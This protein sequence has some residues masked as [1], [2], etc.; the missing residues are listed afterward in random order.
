[1]KTINQTSN[2]MITMLQKHNRE[3]QITCKRQAEM[4]DEQQRQI[5]M[6]ILLLKDRLADIRKVVD[7]AILSGDN[8]HLAHQKMKHWIISHSNIAY[9]R[10]AR[11][12]IQQLADICC[13]G[14]ISK[15]RETYPPLRNDELT[16]CAYIC[17]DF[18]S[19]QICYLG[20]YKN[21]NS[22]YNI[23]HRIKCKLGKHSSWELDVILKEMISN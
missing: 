9:N 21:I 17:L 15:L 11:N 20:K 5:E 19:D 22:L 8:P 4:L 7:I 6:Y 18:S 2:S 1:M 12:L 3:L 13:K 23:R 16:I 10:V 14:I